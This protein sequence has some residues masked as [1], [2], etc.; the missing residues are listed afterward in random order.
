MLAH[1]DRT[2]RGQGQVA[3]ISGEAGIG[4]SHLCEFF[5]DQLAQERH[6]CIRYQCSPHHIHSPFY[7]VVCQLELA[8]GLEQT[9]PPALKFEKLKASLSQAAG[10]TKEDILLYAALLSISAPECEAALRL[11]PQRQKDLTI[12]ALSRHL[13]GFTD[14]EPLIVAFADAHWADPSTLEF[15]S[16]IISLIKTAR[17]LLLIT[18][19]LNLCRNG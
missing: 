4:K 15:I 14:K 5:L 10:P 1:W 19:D 6:L 17:V 18:F 13:L 2:K 7:P 11:T 16:R 8:A 9:D 12:A 3:L